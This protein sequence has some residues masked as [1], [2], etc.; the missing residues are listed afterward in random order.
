MLSVIP[1]WWDITA[2]ITFPSDLMDTLN[3]FMEYDISLSLEPTFMGC[4]FK[5]PKLEFAE[6]IWKSKNFFGWGENK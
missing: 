1:T 4:N 6:Q 2:L 3:N 5:A